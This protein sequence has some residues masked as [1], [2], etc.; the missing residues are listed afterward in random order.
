L[1]LADFTTVEVDRTFQVELTR[2]DSFRVAITTDDNLLPHVQTLKDGSRLR[3]SV[4]PNL[5]SFSATSLK[6]TIAMPSL[7]GLRAASGTRVTTKG[8]KS[9]K[10]FQA[11]IA[12]ST[13][14]GDIEASS[15]DLDVAGSGRVTLKGQ[16]KEIKISASQACRL[17]LA[18]FAVDRADVTLTDR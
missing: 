5:K 12:S 10:A 17:S 7:E 6:A 15:V 3:L 4:D 8:F 13:L 16:A 2:A 18:D 1:Q 9:A 11:N 14:E